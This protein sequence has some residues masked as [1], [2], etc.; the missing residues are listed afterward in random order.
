MF[1]RRRSALELQPIDESEEGEEEQERESVLELPTLGSGGSLAPSLPPDAVAVVVEGGA[2][3]SGGLG[4]S[5]APTRDPSV[6]A[7]MPL[8]EHSPPSI[9]VKPPPHRATPPSPSPAATPVARGAALSHAGSLA[10]GRPPLPAPSPRPVSKLERMRSQAL[11]AAVGLEAGTRSNAGMELLSMGRRTSGESERA[12]PVRRAS[13]GRTP[14]GTVHGPGGTVH[15]GAGG[16]V[17]GSG[18]VGGTMH[19]GMALGAASREPSLAGAATA[20]VTF[21]RAPPLKRSTSLQSHKTTA[22]AKAPAPAATVD[23]VAKKASWARCGA[24]KGVQQEGWGA[25]CDSSQEWLSVSLGAAAHALCCPSILPST[26]PRAHSPSP[27]PPSCSAAAGAEARY[28]DEQQ[29]DQQAAAA[30]AEDEQDG[31]VHPQA[32]AGGG[33]VWEEVGGNRFGA[34]C[35]ACRAP[36]HCHPPKRHCAC[37]PPAGH[38]PGR[39]EPRGAQREGDHR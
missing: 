22:T 21:A 25:P 15:G 5:A 10:A 4:S 31:E 24:W 38:V 7:D 27:C 2:A 13:M 39:A 26:L 37:L 29:P 12:A 23:P 9:A 33:W 18:S 11:E 35:A 32:R 20:R 30:G 19:G 16:T 3:G 14:E 8:L 28:L 1:W 6:G 34:V 17:H 36:G